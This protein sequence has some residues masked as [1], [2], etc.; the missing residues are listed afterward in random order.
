MSN[1]QA[2]LSIALLVVL[3]SAVLTAAMRR[4]ALARNVVDLPNERSSHALP[5]PRG[6]GVAIV[7][8]F[9]MAVIA[10]AASLPTG[11]VV[12][13]VVGGLGAAAVGFADDHGHIA[14]RW[15]LLAHFA[16]AGAVIVGIG[17]PP[18]DWMGTAIDLGPIGI[19]LGAL[20][21]VWMLNLYNFMDGIDGIAGVQAV[22]V[23][24]GAVAAYGMAGIGGSGET[25][26]P[27]LLAAA[28][29]GFLVWNFPTAKIFMGDAGSG[30]VG[31][32]L[33]AMSLH[34]AV[35]HP[36][37]LWCWGVLMGVFI[38]DATTTLLRRLMRRERV[39]EAHRSHAYQHAARWA[40]SHRPVTLA[41]AAINLVWLL[42]WAL[43]A[44]AGWVP[45]AIALV[46]AYL[47]LLGI[48]AHYR[49]GLP[50]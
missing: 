21:L 12:A 18:L 6:G 8:S 23:G 44:A 25:S 48:A 10:S 47:P 1:S 20:Y 36:P 30:F 22:T 2:A 41:V 27:L 37:L 39:Y 5:T 49:A 14:A 34:A 24:V 13:V 46:L 3:V 16:C 35:T 32:M 26:L 33:A 50:D 28:S 19:V 29:L 11:V 15:R 17:I 43:A 9:L 31:L 38:V 40:G 7:A 45:G 42:P 4:Y